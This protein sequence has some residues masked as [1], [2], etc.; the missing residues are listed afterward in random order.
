[1]KCI[2]L[3]AGY[4]TRLY[5]LTLNTPKPLLKV[6][7]HT[8]LDRILDKVEKV[9]EVDQVV[10]V[11][12][13]KFFSHFESWK[14]TYKGSKKIEILNDGTSSNETRLGAIKDIMFAV[15]QLKINDDV[16]LLAGDNLFDFELVDFVLFQSFKDKDCIT[17]HVIED[18][19]KLKKTGVA[20][21]S[22]AFI[23]TSFEEKPSEPKSHY[24]VPPFYIYK[25]DTL[26]LI[27]QF[28]E[29]GNNGDAPGMLL[30]WLLERKPI[31][32]YFFQGNRYDIGDIESYNEAQSLFAK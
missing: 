3:A 6:A 15:E 7:G 9:N 16:L 1:M 12:N 25:K 11:S 2:I 29:E 5:P 20:E 22:N 18:S 13:D 10:V 21:F 24:A 8:I 32:V 14:K 17:S 30:S 23:L 19:E 4:A 31:A 27:S 28:I 26:P